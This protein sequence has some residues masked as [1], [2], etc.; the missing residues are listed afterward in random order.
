MMPKLYF[1]ATRTMARSTRV[2]STQAAL[3]ASSTG[4]ISAANVSKMRTGGFEGFEE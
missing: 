4:E 2:R 3:L 1:L